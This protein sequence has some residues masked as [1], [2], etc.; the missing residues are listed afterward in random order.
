MKCN[1]LRY[2]AELVRHVLQ[3]G[4][5]THPKLAKLLF[6]IDRELYKRFGA[7]AFRW[8][9]SKYGPLSCEVLDAVEELET[10][11]LV[12]SRFANG[13]VIYELTSTAPAE[14]PQ[15]VK[16]VADKVLETWAHRSLD[17]LTEY[18]NELEEV[19][20]TSPGRR[21]LC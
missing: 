6:L 16:E 12:V 14:L 15:E 3:R 17:D 7:T 13:A 10:D 20:K 8:R 1:E 2:Q 4:P 5:M 18:I 19:K 9:M 21:L 11:G